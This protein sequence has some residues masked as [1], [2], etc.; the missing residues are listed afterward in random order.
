M[1][2]FGRISVVMPSF[3]YGRFVADAVESVLRQTYTGDVE[4]IVVDDG[5]TDDTQARL[6]PYAGRIRSI[7]QDNSGVSVARNRGI[8]EA[9]GDWIA[10]LDADDQWHPQTLEMLANVASAHNLDVV[11]AMTVTDLA[12]LPE[13]IDVNPPIEMIDFEHVASYVPLA[14]SATMIRREVLLEAGL[15]D[16]TILGPE[17]RAM[18]MR[19]AMTK[20]IGQAKC[21]A[22]FYRLHQHQLTRN[23]GKM[24]EN[25][26]RMLA[27]FFQQ[28]PERAHYSR[29]AYSY[30]HVDAGIAFLEVN[31]HSVAMRHLVKSLWLHPW[32]PSTKGHH[33][34]VSRVKLLIRSMLGERLFR[35]LRG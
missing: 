28:F 34:T 20:R 29:F 2:S 8:R 4:L 23:P 9:T 7:V 19:L 16:E 35:M 31:N 1:S 13:R 14:P 32:A 3:D 12:E 18:W 21:P 11:S 17:D 24:L 15:F 27:S 26:Q 6:A 30:M 10:L 5:S 22:V 33:S 25:Y